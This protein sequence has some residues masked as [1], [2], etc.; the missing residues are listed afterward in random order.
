MCL[1]AAFERKQMLARS[2]SREYE[3]TAAGEEQLR[4]WNIDPAQL[5]QSRR[6]FARRC[7]DW[8]ER[9]DHLAGAVGAAICQKFLDFH[10]LRR[11]RNSRVVH[12]SPQ[13]QRELERLLV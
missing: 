2:G 6:S 3:L 12:V 13:G 1:A 7:L 5:R 10:W 9:R 4:Q 11:E 8:T